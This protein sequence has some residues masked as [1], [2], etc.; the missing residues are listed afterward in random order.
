VVGSSAMCSTSLRANDSDLARPGGASGRRWDHRAA[1]AASTFL[2]ASRIVVPFPLGA[3]PSGA[4]VPNGARDKDQG[5]CPKSR[6]A[7]RLSREERDGGR[8]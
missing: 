1:T 7:T 6:A 2:L 8:R 5:L 4:E 3:G